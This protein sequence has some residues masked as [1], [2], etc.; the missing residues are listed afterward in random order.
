MLS[1][2]YP[3]YIYFSPELKELFLMFDKDD[4]GVIS[5][6]EVRTILRSIG[7]DP[8]SHQVQQAMQQFDVDGKI[9]IGSKMVSLW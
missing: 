8:S 9:T 2:Q 3:V 7:Q 4:D 1:L 6:M 5:T